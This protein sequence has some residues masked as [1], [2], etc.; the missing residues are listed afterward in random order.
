MNC[1]LIL[2]MGGVYTYIPTLTEAP[3][4]RRFSHNEGKVGRMQRGKT[5]GLRPKG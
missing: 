1:V 4:K 5:E 3:I 2:G